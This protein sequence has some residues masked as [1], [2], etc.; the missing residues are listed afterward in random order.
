MKLSS[1]LGLNARSQLLTY[2]HNNK[3]GRRI[4]G[5]KLLTKRILAKAKIPVPEIYKK[6]KHPHDVIEFDW[7]SL[8][9]SFT[10]KPSKGFGGEGIIILKKKSENEKGWINSQGQEVSV[11]D[12]KLHTLD[13]LEGAYSYGNFPDLAYIEEYVEVADTL[14]P[15]TYKGTPDIRVIV[16]NKVPVMAMLRLP[17]IESEGKANIHQ[18]A[19]GVGIDIGSGTTTNAVWHGSLIK[20]KPRSKR[21]LKGIKIPHWDKILEIAILCQEAS[22]LGYLGADM[23]IHPKRGPL[24]LELNSYPGLQIQLA[25]MAG[26]KK[27]IER[28]EDLQVTS[29][30]HGVKIA[31]A[32][33]ASKYLPDLR[34]E[35]V[36]IVK[37]VEDVKVYTAENKRISVKGRIDTGAFRSSIDKSL[38]DKLGLLNP[39]N[40]LWRDTYRSAIGTQQRPIIGLTIFFAGKKIQTT[41]S[42]TNRSKMTTP[43]LIG[44]NDLNNILVKIGSSDET[45]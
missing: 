31:K 3:R 2:P 34:Y 28:V 36:K 20:H 15:F 10:L 44:R 13:I 24:V 42:V 22:G 4:A 23:V 14:K 9:H 35:S 27:R 43:L 5:S 33:F 40:I 29:V 37:G 32:L 21:K 11:D 39:E 17:T 38:A 1:I 25:N 12:L 18:G 8:P 45:Q 41:A 30:E 16:F 6:F 19:I 7:Q 26:L